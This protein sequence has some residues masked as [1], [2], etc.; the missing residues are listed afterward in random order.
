MDTINMLVEESVLIVS[1]VCDVLLHLV[2]EKEKIQGMK[3]GD[4]LSCCSLLTPCS[5]AVKGA[6]RVGGGCEPM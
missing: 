3:A 1:C 2:G 6:G 4:S 5:H